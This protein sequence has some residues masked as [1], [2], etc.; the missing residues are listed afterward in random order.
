MNHRARRALVST[1]LAA[2]MLARSGAASA[3]GGMFCDSGPM[4][5]PVDQKGENILFAMDGT[6][7]EAHIQ[8][9]YKGDAHRFAWVLPVQSTPVVS[10]GS[11][12][13]FDG[14]LRA[15]VPT[16]GYTTS[17]DPCPTSAKGGASGYPAGQGGAGGASS[18]GGTTV[19]Y[20]ATVGAFDV[21]VLQGGTAD[22]VVAWLDTNGYQQN[23]DATPILGQYLEKNYLFLAIKLTSGAGTDAIHPLVIK[24][25]GTEPC[26]PLKLTA[27]AAVEDMG[28]RTFFLGNGR[29]VPSNY[30]HITL[31]ETRFDWI[32]LAANYDQAVS[33]AAD[34]AVA[35]GQAFVTEYAGPSSAVAPGPIYGNW[36]A[37]PFASLPVEGVVE[38]L[39]KQNLMVCSGYVSSGSPGGPPKM[40][41]PDC[42]YQH[43]LLQA[44]VNEYI[45]VPAGVTEVAFYNCLSCNKTKIDAK[46]WDGAA[47]SKAMD[48][49]IVAPGKHAVE[50]LSTWPYLTRMFTE[51]SPAEMGTDPEFHERADLPP[52]ASGGLGTRR[53]TCDGQ[54]GITLPDTRDVA[55]T[56]DSTWPTWSDEMPWAETIEEIPVSGDP[57]RLVDNTKKINDLVAAWNLSRHWPPST[58]GASGTGGTSGGTGGTSGGTG[59]TS[60]GTG[61]A[62]AAPADEPSG[63]CAVGRSASSGGW[64]SLALLGLALGRRRRR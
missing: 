54:S 59:G 46:A 24:Y 58:A 52:V 37:V 62:S 1:L 57:I 36:D 5:M 51:I 29:W 31:N 4:A 23:P 42:G 18:G 30:K 45:P 25:H 32:N 49:R 22:E 55:L 40:I 50:L 12:L 8:I 21:S 27:I 3:C 64:I 38:E 11:Q 63:G 53:I 41:G 39:K 19:V 43:P 14:L 44:L 13:L 10:V 47:F 15:T 56:A 7:V 61:G 33:L 26:V 34:S 20:Q 17:R 60:G 28:V 6:T 2:G 48:E 9:Q 35:N 16:W